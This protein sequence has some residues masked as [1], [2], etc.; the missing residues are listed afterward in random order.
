LTIN[1][2]DT[3]TADA[4]TGPDTTVEYDGPVEYC[5]RVLRVA[6][7]PTQEAIATDL[8]RHPY[9]VLCR[10]GHN[11]GKS[12]LAACLVNWW[13]DSYAPSICLTTAPTQRQVERILWRE[14]RMLRGRA[15]LGGFAGPKMPRLERSPDHFAEGFTA[16][17]GSRFQG[18][19]SPNVLIIFDE[20]EGVDPIF[21]EAAESMLG[22]DN[23][24]FL[25]IYNPTSQS[26]QAAQEEKREGYNLVTMS[27][28]DHPNI[29]DELAGNKP[30]YPSAIR[31]GRLREMLAKWCTLVAPGER[32]EG[33]VQLGEQVYR[34]GPVAQARL[35][36]IRPD[37]AFNTIWSE[38]MFAATVSRV[39]PL[40][41]PLQIGCDV[42]RFGDDDTALHVRQG[43]NSVYHES[44]NGWSVVQ[45][46]E[47]C[48]Q[49][50]TRFGREM[51]LDPRRALI[52]VDDC[53]VGG[54]VVDILRSEHWN[55]VGVNAASA[56]VAP[57]RATL[58]GDEDHPNLRSALW[59]G[60]A[61][62]AREGNVSFARLEQ[63]VQQ[64]LRRELTAPTY[65]LD[66]RGRRVVEPKDLTKKRLG[67]SPDNADAV[68][69]AYAT[70]GMTPEQI[71]GII[72]V[73]T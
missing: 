56:Y 10:S 68:H 38:A 16:R 66:V 67:N 43:G 57:R 37:L 59:F 26:S 18:H 28:L 21:W 41:G 64:T 53:G 71:G 44:A 42:A 13:F 52:A 23:H 9:R 20:A 48:K 22:G 4:S 25:A 30:S 58:A 24:A 32:L 27:C 47:R 3:W 11:V 35:L 63:H 1:A 49:V 61:D 7:T 36:G 45:T 62:A 19:H 51:R 54:G 5:E 69:L 31:L 60:L 55:V 2:I 15:S 12:F 46:A 17:D 39:L 70:V 65:T 33:D 73:P 50:A 40:G 29:A 14:V 72:P 34:P 8:T 6:L